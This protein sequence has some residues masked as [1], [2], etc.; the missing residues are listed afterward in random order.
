[1]GW[2]RIEYWKTDENDK[3]MELDDADLEHIAEL[4][5]ERYTEGEVC[6]GD[7]KDNKED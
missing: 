3:D 6:D 4:I 2:W 1:M 7:S 5:K